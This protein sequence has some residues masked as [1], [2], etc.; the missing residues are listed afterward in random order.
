[1]KRKDMLDIIGGIDENFIEEATPKTFAAKRRRPTMLRLVSAAACFLV[2]AG[3]GAGAFAWQ[4]RPLPDLSGRFETK[5]VARSEN[6]FN[7]NS[8]Q[9]TISAVNAYMG[10]SY[11]SNYYKR[12]SRSKKIYE[13]L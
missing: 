3:I 8:A 1:M 7:K 10:I 12:K 5:Y 13:L 2:A 9:T 6:Y 4:T 11:N